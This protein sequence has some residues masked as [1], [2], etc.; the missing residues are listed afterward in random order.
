MAALEVLS[1]RAQYFQGTTVHGIEEAR[2]IAFSSDKD[3]TP[4]TWSHTEV[5]GRFLLPNVS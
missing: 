1:M 4:Y 2:K 3:M 5:P